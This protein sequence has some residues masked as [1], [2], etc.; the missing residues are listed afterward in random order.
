[1]QNRCI[2]FAQ[3]GLGIMIAY[4]KPVFHEKKTI[5]FVQIKKPDITGKNICH[6]SARNY[7]I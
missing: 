5:S 4:E 1:M 3:I 6:L 2:T 7:L